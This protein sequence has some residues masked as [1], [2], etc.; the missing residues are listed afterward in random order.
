LLPSWQVDLSE[1]SGLNTVC[2]TYE[3]RWLATTKKFALYFEKNL[4]SVLSYF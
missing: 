2:V 3:K 4:Y 1:N